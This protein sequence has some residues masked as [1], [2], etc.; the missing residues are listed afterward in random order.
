MM[1]KVCL[2]LTTATFA[3]SA[4]CDSS[5]AQTCDDSQVKVIDRPFYPGSQ[6]RNQFKYH[7]RYLPASPGNPTLVYIPGGPGETSINTSFDVP[8]GYGL[9]LTDP[10]G[11]GCNQIESRA[12][13]RDEFYTTENIALD[14]LAAVAMTNPEK[15]ILYGR[16]YGTMVATVAA[17]L[18]QQK[19]GMEPLAVV[20]QG[21]VGQA[22]LGDSIFQGYLDTWATEKS[23]L[24]AS[25]LKTF[26][27]GSPLGYSS[28]V[29][30]LTVANL[31][32]MGKSAQGDSI[33]FLQGVLPNSPIQNSLEQMVSSFLPQ[34][35][36]DVAQLYRAIVCHEVSSVV[37]TP[38]VDVDLQLINGDLVPVKGHLCDGIPL[39]RPY[40]SRDWQVRAPIYY[41]AGSLDPATPIKGARFH[42]EGQPR[43][44][45]IFV[46]VVDGGH[47]A[48]E[49]GLGDCITPILQSIGN[50]GESF[51]DVLQTC[52]L[53]TTVRRRGSE[54]AS[55]SNQESN[56]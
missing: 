14:I 56:N 11:V 1:G 50:G 9:I 27:Q 12:S 54:L 4:F 24:P 55:E 6:S 47:R 39:D 15:Y 51:E 43:S 10:R 30:G 20:L 31:L 22:F 26:E 44:N 45:R 48:L 19:I 18:A 37:S 41:F 36:A 17:S 16:S 13:L 2:F 21:V 53:K 25:V 3:L 32:A 28:S 52:V 38:I 5:F 8:D 46:T 42:F 29:W 49:S 23:D 40:N 35:S 7:F 33:Q 34:S